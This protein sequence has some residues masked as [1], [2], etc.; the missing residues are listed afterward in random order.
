LVKDSK[1]WLA[2]HNLNIVERYKKAE[3]EMV[4]EFRVSSECDKFHLVFSSIPDMDIGHT[5]LA[6]NF[7]ANP[8]ADDASSDG[9]YHFVLIPVTN[10]IE[11]PQD[12]IASQVRLEP[13]KERLDFFRYVLGPSETVGHLTNASSERES[14][15]LRI[16]FARRDCYSVPSVIKGV[17]EIV[18]NVASNIGNRRGNFLR[19]FD[20]VN[21]MVRLIRVRLNNSLVW[22]EDAR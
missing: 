8:S 16:D 10:F 12:I 21:H 20:L 17:S 13:A 5:E 4:V 11:C 6:H 22:I 2:I 19:H 7:D 18:H 1:N 14:G 9:D 3:L 15:E